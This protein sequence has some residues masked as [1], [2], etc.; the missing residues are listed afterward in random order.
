M[1][2]DE[3]AGR[4]VPQGTMTPQEAGHQLKGAKVFSEFN[5]GNGFHQVPLA[6][7]SQV[8]FQ[9]HLGLHRMKRL[10]FR[11]NNSSGIFHHE[12]IKVFA[13]LKGCVTIHD[14]LLVFGCDEDEHNRNMAA[15][16]E[17]ARE[18]G[19]TLKLSKSTILVAEVKWFR[20]VYLEAGM[21]R[22]TTS[23][24]E[25]IQVMR[26][27]MADL[28]PALTMAVLREVAERDEIYRVT[29]SSC[30]PP[31]KQS[32]RHGGSSWTLSHPVPEAQGG[33]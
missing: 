17:S 32:P 16:L 23:C 6:T 7:G 19:V 12:V 30:H 27:I 31:K 1:Y 24:R 21:S 9:S 22:Y 4:D 33:R 10:S 5:M 20:R 8:I 2:K 15:M 13:G 29:H 3:D 18:K 25:D 28:L 11:P 14:N 26:V